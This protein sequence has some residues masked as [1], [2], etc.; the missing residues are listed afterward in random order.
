MEL[1]T[2][3]TGQP[4]NGKRTKLRVLE[5]RQHMQKRSCVRRTQQRT[6]ARRERFAL[7]QVREGTLE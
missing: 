5:Q 7:L 1:T 4:R 6:D 2:K 3:N